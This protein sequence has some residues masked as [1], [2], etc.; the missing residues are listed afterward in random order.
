M[1]FGYFLGKLALYGP[2]QIPFEVRLIPLR[3]W[4]FVAFMVGITKDD[5]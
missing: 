2:L 4:A 1:N 3:V 5:V